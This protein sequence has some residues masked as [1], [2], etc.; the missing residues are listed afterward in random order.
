MAGAAWVVLRKELVEALRDRRTLVL[1]LLLP[2]VVMPAVTLGLPYLAL[3]EES[4]LRSAPARVAVRGAAYLEDLLQMASRDGLIVV[5]PVADAAAALRKGSV[6]AV[7]DAAPGGPG[8]AV[9]VRLLYDEESVPSLLARQKLDQAMAQ[10]SLAL[11]EARLAAGGIQVEHLLPLQVEHVPIRPAGE[12]GRTQLALL[13]PFF[14][15]VWIL[16]GGQYAALDLGA[17]ERE[18]GTLPG[19]L[20]TPASR[21]GLVVGKFG[22]VFVLATSS[23]LLV[24]ASVLVSLKL[25]PPL[26]S[27]LARG[28]PWGSALLLVGTG[29]VFAAFLSAL[30][31]LLSLAARS[32][33]EAQQLFTPL[34]L[35][36][37]GSVL[38]AQI[39]PEWGQEPWP[40][41][42]PAVNAAY[43]LRGLLLDAVGA[44]EYAL[45]LGGLGALTAATLAAGAWIYNRERASD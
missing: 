3:Q 36:T 26:G 34:Y 22:A 21:L 19:L 20:L 39:L 38:L 41:L 10:Y 24:V 9:R 2:I 44:R 42:L 43:L 14:M 4:R 32:V 40:Y 6:H 15:T 7:L 18:R 17:G 16:L 8:D 11:V 28:I 1:G 29:L 45:A 25:A 27:A 35:L 30:Q 13:L 33:R 23:V 31:L 5:V 37:V 12:A